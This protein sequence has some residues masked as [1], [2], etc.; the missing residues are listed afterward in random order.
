M[1]QSIAGLGHQ[2]GDL[3]GVVMSL[4]V[5]RPDQILYYVGLVLSWG[6]SAALIITLV[7]LKCEPLRRVAGVT[8]LGLRK[9]VPFLIAVVFV[10]IVQQIGELRGLVAKQF[11]RY[12]VP[13]EPLQLD[14]VITKIERDIAK[15]GSERILIR[16]L[17]LDLTNAWEQVNPKLLQHLGK[18]PVRYELLI[19]RVPPRLRDPQTK[20]LIDVKLA[21]DYPQ[22]MAYG[23]PLDVL[24]WCQDG[25]RM[26]KDT[27]IRDLESVSA[28]PCLNFEWEVRQYSEIPFPHGF[29]TT[30]DARGSFY[31]MTLCR[32]GEETPV[33]GQYKK[34][35]WA[36]DNYI[37]LSA[38]NEDTEKID[39]DFARVFDGF[40]AHLWSTNY[41]TRV[42]GESPKLPRSP[43]K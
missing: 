29:R 14:Q 35:E 23:F 28:K 4:L 18:R 9:K 40:F 11:E 38:P 22:G 39:H 3:L 43:G 21:P 19:L 25:E 5:L 12:F 1:T 32:W 20:Q 17:G 26:L 24:K 34:W 36:P 42:F 13:R 16:H 31:Y 2:Q 6:A 27:V 7:L 10:A 15:Q 37:E 33:S 8:P 30:T 41:D